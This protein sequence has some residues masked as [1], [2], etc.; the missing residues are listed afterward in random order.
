MT[1]ENLEHVN[2]EYVD[3][4]AEPEEAS[5]VEE[6]TVD[7]L[8]EKYQGKTAAD[9]ARM[10]QEA[11]KMMGRQSS[12]VGELRKI[13]D[14]FVKV[15]L[16]T[17]QSQQEEVYEDTNEDIDFFEDPNRA[18]D[19]AIRKHPKVKEAEQAT[20]QL[21]Q[22]ETVA[23]IK[24]AHPDFLEV[25]QDT[26]FQEWISKS[27]IRS[28]LLNEADQQYNF[29][30][31]DELLTSWKERQSIVTQAAK[32]ETTARKSQVKQAS[33]GAAR[34]SGEGRSRKVYRR[35]DIIK[36]MQTDPDRY[37]ALAGE[38]RQAYAEG[39]VK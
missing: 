2:E 17:Q 5:P 20:A 35:A 12:E 7:E 33:T 21:R 30:A 27:K 10:H 22:Q 18:I 6:P 16:Q 8:P 3:F 38:I 31:A 19:A 25:V 11:E 39:R 1:D 14:D 23:R 34:G 24:A 15:Q 29:D 26:A 4:D 36:L 13:V 28:R 37:M 32:T 9:I